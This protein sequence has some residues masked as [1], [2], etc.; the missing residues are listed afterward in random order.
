MIEIESVTKKTKYSH[1]Q[2][3]I[4]YFLRFYSFVVKSLFF[5]KQN[6]T[7]KDAITLV[8]VGWKNPR[9]KIIL[10]TLYYSCNS[11]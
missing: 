2:I 1:L 10:Y 6:K 4:Y 5:N 8:H 9:N 7:R 3:F 11:E